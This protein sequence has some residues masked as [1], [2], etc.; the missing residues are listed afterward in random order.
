MKNKKFLIAGLI[1]LFIVGIVYVLAMETHDKSGYSHWKKSKFSHKNFG[2][3]SA[4]S[5]KLDLPQDATKAQI[6]E[7]LKA[8]YGKSKTGHAN[9]IGKKHRFKKDASEENV[10]VIWPNNKEGNNHNSWKKDKGC[11]FHK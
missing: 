3:K 2:D 6:M 10:A 11:G 8:H 9:K 4:W 5:E 7:A 1:A